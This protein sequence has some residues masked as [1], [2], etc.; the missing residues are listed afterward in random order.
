[1]RYIA[2]PGRAAGWWVVDAEGVSAYHNPRYMKW[3]PR[4]EEAEAH[5]A[6]LNTHEMNGGN[7]P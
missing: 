5:A 1:M 2:E 6:N 3:F 7:T 4:Q